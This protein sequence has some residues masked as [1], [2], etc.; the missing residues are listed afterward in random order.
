MA[1]GKSEKQG[2]GELLFLSKQGNPFVSGITI[3]VEPKTEFKDVWHFSEA[4]L[5][6]LT[7]S[8]EP[9][10]HKLRVT[11]N[12][13]SLHGKEAREIALSHLAEGELHKQ[14]LL[15]EEGEDRFVIVDYS[16]VEF[17]GEQD[18]PIYEKIKESLDV[19]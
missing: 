19:E 5:R 17:S 9:E 15:F 10:R 18:L 7:A 1:L 4:Y 16:R 14:T 12:K 13:L 11:K 8:M 6:H 3:T 2:E